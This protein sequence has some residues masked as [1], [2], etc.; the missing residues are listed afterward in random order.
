MWNVFVT[1]A[2]KI[3]GARQQVVRKIL[4]PKKLIIIGHFMLLRNQKCCVYLVLLGLWIV[5]RCSGMGIWLVWGKDCMYTDFWWGNF[6]VSAPLEDRVN[7]CEG[8]DEF[9]SG[10]CPWWT[11]DTFNVEPANIMLV[12]CVVLSAVDCLRVRRCMQT[13]RCAVWHRVFLVYNVWHSAGFVCTAWLSV[14]DR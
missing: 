2:S 3:R 12:Y 1:W 13:V 10:W 6:V 7:R 5:E 9:G 4:R 14:Y 8:E 11:S